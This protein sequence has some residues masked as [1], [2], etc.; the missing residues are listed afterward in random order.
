MGLVKAEQ[1]Y[2]NPEAEVTYAEL[3]VS[4]IRLAHELSEKG[5]DLRY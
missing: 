1:N 5:N 3:A 4:I 2:F